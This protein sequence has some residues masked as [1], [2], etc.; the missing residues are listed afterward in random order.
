[1]RCAIYRSITAVGVILFCAGANVAS[2]EEPSVTR[3]VSH[4]ALT[5]Q[6]GEKQESVKDTAPSVSSPHLFALRL[7]PSFQKRVGF[8]FGL[9]IT[10]PRLHLIP[11]LTTRFTLEGITLSRDASSLEDLFPVG[12]F[13]LEQIYQRP[14][15]KGFRPYIGAGI[16]VYTGVL[17]AKTGGGFLGPTYRNATVP[18]GKLILGA[19]FTSTTG[20][21]ATIHFAGSQTVGTLQLRLKL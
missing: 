12:A 9:D 16:G 17:G 1:M 5:A 15:G 6:Q 3:P 7:G 20:I 18:G 19:D 13:T 8:A 4:S 10:A 21:E 14:A 2:A 11:A